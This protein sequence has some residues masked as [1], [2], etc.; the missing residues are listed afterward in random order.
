VQFWAYPLGK[1]CV[2]ILVMAQCIG[3]YISLPW[4]VVNPKI[5]I[6]NQLKPSTLSQ[7][8]VVLREYVFE[9]LVVTVYLTS[10]TDEVVPPY[11]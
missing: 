9:T 11:L 10:M 5:I 2:A 4:V 6:L 1:S 3:Y 8:Q 7:I